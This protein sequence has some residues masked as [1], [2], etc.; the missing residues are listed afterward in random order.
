LLHLVGLISPLY[1]YSVAYW[2]PLDMHSLLIFVP[3][4]LKDVIWWGD[5][6]SARTLPTSTYYTKRPTKRP[7]FHVYTH[8]L[9]SW[10]FQ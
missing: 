4:L 9:T 10:Y 6:T 3:Y 7:A 5:T 8:F 2:C 1:E